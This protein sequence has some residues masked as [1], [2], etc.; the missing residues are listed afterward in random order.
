LRPDEHKAPEWWRE[1]AL[2]NYLEFKEVM[3]THEGIVPENELVERESR[4]GIVYK[5]DTG[6][7]EE[8]MLYEA[9]FVRPKDGVGLDVEMA[10]LSPAWPR[11]GVLKIGGESRGARYRILDKPAEAMPRTP[12]G[13]CFKL[14]FATPAYLERGW[15]PKSGWTKLVGRGVSLVGAALG[16]PLV[17]GGF[18]LA[19]KEH[20]PSRRF[21]PAGSVYYFKG[22][23]SLQ[24]AITQWGTEIGLGHCFVGGWIC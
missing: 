22:K 6:T 16:R 21:I 10:A 20:K 11:S 15:R 3:A 7:V 12:L 1:D 8:G 2:K 13:D 9:E 18:D 17:I 4:V 24:G 5:E 14:Y 23:A 19:K